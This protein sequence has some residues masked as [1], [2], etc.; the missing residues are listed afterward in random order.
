[1]LAALFV[2]L[3][4]L[5]EL[6]RAL[7]RSGR[8]AARWLGRVCSSPLRG[9]GRFMSTVAGTLVRL[10]RRPARWVTAALVALVPSTGRLGRWMARRLLPLG[11]RLL[12]VGRAVGAALTS[13]GRVL[14]AVGCRLRVA[15]RAVRPVAAPL[16]R[17]LMVVLARLGRGLRL[18]A[19]GL[20]SVLWFAALGA[21]TVLGWFVLGVVRCGTACWPVAVRTAVPFRRLA[22]AAGRTVARR[23]RQAGREFALMV[24][25]IARRLVP[26]LEAL[27][28]AGGLALGTARG[29]ARRLA[30]TTREADR[31]LVGNSEAGTARRGHRPPSRRREIR[32]GAQAADGVAFSV[33]VSQN[34]YLGVGAGVVDAVVSVAAV[35]ERPTSDSTTPELAEVILLDCSASMGHPPRKMAA[36]RQATQAAIDCLRDGV[37][38][39]VVRCAG[40]AE[41]VYPRE[42]TLA[43]A[44]PQTRRE[45]KAV[46]AQLDASGG[47]AFGRW[48]L[49]ARD[50][51]QACPTAIHHALLLTDG[52]DEGESPEDLLAALD[53]CAGEFQCDCRGVGTDWQVAE[54]RRVSASLLGPVDIIPDPAGMVAD[55]R[56]ITEWA[57]SRVVSDVGLRIWTPR[58]ARL[59]FVRQVAPSIEDL[60]SAPIDPRTEEFATGAWGREARRYLVRVRVTPGQEGSEMLAARVQV[61]VGTT[62]RG[63][64]KVLATWTR[65]TAL[66]GYIDP[67]VARATGRAELATA[68]REGLAAKRRGDD[69][70]ATRQLGRA[71]QLASQTASGNIGALLANVVDVEDAATGTVTLRRRA[72]TVDEMLLDARSTKTGPTDP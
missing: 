39:A 60:E 52:R 34:A 53:E 35:V 1:V 63:D 22:A 20:A 26:R 37:A 2:P 47:T 66:A 38:F 71:V 68:V 16:C 46:A 49:A 13:V 72:S 32:R 23:L 58:G 59:D 57:M 51:F 48:L 27:R 45:A 42:S 70:G 5:V 14:T 7:V 69:S 61:V 41:V 56:A 44:S 64:A 4:V 8:H 31:V 18:V 25:G 19:A 30:H 54:L 17:A 29:R 67:E 40:E 28:L 33:T 55:F 24:N 10:A 15:G 3:L 65:D 62:A 43:V 11:R 12:T 9:L 50:L 21:G 6:P 36:A